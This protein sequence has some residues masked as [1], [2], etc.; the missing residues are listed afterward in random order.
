[1]EGLYHVGLAVG[2]FSSCPSPFSFVHLALFLTEF[3]D[4]TFQ[5]GVSPPPKKNNDALAH[6]KNMNLWL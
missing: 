2:V 4:A 5:T 1:M 3:Q 6:L